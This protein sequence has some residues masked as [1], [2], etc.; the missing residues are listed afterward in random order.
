M[1]MPPT[2][3]DT[4]ELLRDCVH[5][6]IHTSDTGRCIGAGPLHHAAGIIKQKDALIRSQAARIKELE[7][8]YQQLMDKHNA[9]HINA[10]A[11][12]DRVAELEA[13]TQRT[14]LGVG[15]FSEL[16]HDAQIAFCLDKYPSYEAA[17]VKL[18]EAHHNITPPKEPA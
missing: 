12:R 13:L 11:S 18:V 4:I 5:A 10:K 7:A 3:Q 8:D 1:G 16:C 2:E 14:P 15:Q 9:L 17:L 6:V